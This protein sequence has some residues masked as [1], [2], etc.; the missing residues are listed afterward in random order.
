M[1][2]SCCRTGPA[3]AAAAEGV[4]GPEETLLLLTSVVD[5]G[6]R[7]SRVADETD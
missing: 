6:C 4:P 1:I 2:V 7:R 3:D 5:F